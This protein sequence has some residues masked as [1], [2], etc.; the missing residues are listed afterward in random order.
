MKIQR[1]LGFC[2][3]LFPCAG[4]GSGREILWK[5]E[6]TYAYLREK[7]ILTEETV[8]WIFSVAEKWKNSVV[9]LAG[10]RGKLGNKITVHCGFT[11]AYGSSLS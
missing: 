11:R 3:C 1:W 8:L 6:P 4:N 9:L 7:I 5:C 10:E 2:C